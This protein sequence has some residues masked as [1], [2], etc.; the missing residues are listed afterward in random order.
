[1]GN[2]LRVTQTGSHNGR[3][4]VQRT[5]LFGL[6][7][8]KR[9]RTVYVRDTPSARGQIGAVH[10]LVEWAEV[11]DAERDAALSNAKTPSY[12]VVDAKAKAKKKAKPKAAKETEEPAADE[13]D[14]DGE[15]SSDEEA[16]Q[17]TE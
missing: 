7:I 3:L 16:D 6:G 13:A 17:S 9:G 5:T 12:E 11:S 10:H 1:M 15:A 4:A 8:T 14:A 2:W